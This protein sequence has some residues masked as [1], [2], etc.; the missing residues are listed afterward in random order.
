M[1]ML[2]AQPDPLPTTYLL[3]QGRRRG[4][5]LTS[6]KVR[7]A[8]VHKKGRKYQH[9]WL[10]LRSINSI[11]HQQ[12]RHLGFG[13]FIVIWSTLH[14]PTLPPPDIPTISP[15]PSLYFSL[16]SLC[17]A[18]NVCLFWSAGEEGE[19]DNCSYFSVFYSNK[20]VLTTLLQ[21]HPF[22]YLFGRAVWIRT[23]GSCRSNQDNS[24][25]PPKTRSYIRQE[26]SIVSFFCSLGYWVSSHQA[27]T[28]KYSKALIRLKKFRIYG[29]LIVFSNGGL[30]GFSSSGFIRKKM[31]LDAF[32]L[33]QYSILYVWLF[34]T[35]VHR[36]VS[37]AKAS[38]MQLENKI[39]NNKYWII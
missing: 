27:Y 8:L 5:W 7:G 16:S 11:K 21:C 12:R 6:E 17:A 13:V 2:S 25:L 35:I 3:T 10:Y 34:S 24:I 20:S 38:A 36:G 9:D 31:Y 19:P 37:K 23:R 18:S 22:L 26:K 33:I 30:D 29:R 4:G 14:P 28:G 32:L 1:Y 39:I 15:P